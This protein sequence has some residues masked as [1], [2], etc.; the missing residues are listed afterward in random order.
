MEAVKTDQASRDRLHEEQR[1]AKRFALMLRAAKLLCESGEYVGVVRDVSATGAKVRLFHDIPPDTHLFI[2]LANGARYAMERMWHRDSHAGFRF[3]SMIDVTEFMEEASAHTR[4]PLRLRVQG[5]ARVKCKGTESPAAL[6]DISQH[7][8]CI[9]MDRRLAVCEQ[10]RLEVPGLPNRVGH[11]RW[12]KE[13]QH[14]L[15]FQQAFK[16]DEFARHA[17]ALQPFLP[18]LEMPAAVASTAAARCA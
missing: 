2:E 17:F 8:A 14:G 4:R 16:L 15:V 5:P 1:G 6:V 18:A 13:R 11:V 7:G 12:R 9:E 3:S 10:L